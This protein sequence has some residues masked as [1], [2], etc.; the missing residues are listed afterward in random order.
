MVTTLT[1]I[2]FHDQTQHGICGTP[3][4]FFFYSNLPSFTAGCS[5]FI[6]Q[7]DHINLPYTP[8]LISTP[9][10]CLC[11]FSCPE[12]FHP[13]SLIQVHSHLSHETFIVLC[14]TQ[15]SLLMCFYNICSLNTFKHS[16]LHCYITFKC[17]VYTCF[18]SPITQAHTFCLD[19][20]PI[21]SYAK[22]PNT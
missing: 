8:R 3:E 5:L 22:Y 9:Y 2:L 7:V 4:N 15:W 10:F 21:T 18:I 14:R 20:S 16:I 12:S 19:F 11:W 13:Y 17:F 6:H 1:I